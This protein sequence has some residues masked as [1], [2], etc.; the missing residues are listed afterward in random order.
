MAVTPENFTWE[1]A[2]IVGSVVG[3][4]IIAVASATWVLNTSFRK[5]IDQQTAEFM[6]K[7]GL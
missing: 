4:C 7:I 6:K 5:V 1:Q 3:G 2:E